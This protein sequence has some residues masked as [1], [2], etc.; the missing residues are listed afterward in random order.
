M[1]SKVPHSLVQAL[2]QIP[3]FAVLDDRTLLSIVGESMNLFWKAGSYIFRVGDPGE[4]LYVML[5]GECTIFD[6]DPATAQP[7]ANPRQGDSFGELSLLLNT[8]HSKS[9]LAVSDCEILVLPKEAFTSMLTNN[10]ALAGHFDQ[11]LKVR[12][13][14]V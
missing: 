1:E 3:D 12:Q 10:P 7:V 5:E 6:G 11:V 4:A 8:T 13:V 2:R 9:A 14:K